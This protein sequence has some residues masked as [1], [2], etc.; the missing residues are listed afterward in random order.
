M[1]TQDRAKQ[2]LANME[3]GMD[4]KISDIKQETQ[5]KLNE[6]DAKVEDDLSL[7]DQ[8]MARMRE[9]LDEMETK[10]ILEMIMD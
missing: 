2:D 10:V 8:E 4:R 9:R 3:F 6:I 5:I 7:K 1:A